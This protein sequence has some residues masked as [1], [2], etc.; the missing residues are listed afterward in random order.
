MKKFNY[1][2]LE[3]LTLNQEIVN[4]LL[5]INK[6]QSKNDLLSNAKNPVLK[7]YLKSAKFNSI[8]TSNQ[9]EG[10]KTSNYRME[11]IISSPDV[12]P[13]NH[14]ESE[15]IGYKKVLEMINDNYENIA[16]I[17]HHILQLHK[18]LFSFSFQKQFG[19][20]KIDNFIK[21]TFP[22]KTE[23]TRFI[24]SDA[25]ST[26][27]HME[28]LCQ[29]FNLHFH[30]PKINPL[31]ASLNFILDFLCIHPFTDGNGRISRLLTTL[32]L[33]KNDHIIQKF[34]SFEQIIEETKESYYDV[35]FES[36]QNWHENQ[37]DPLP[38]IQY[39]LNVILQTYQKMDFNQI[40]QSS[41]TALQ[42]ITNYFNN[43]IIQ[44]NK[45]TLI[46]KFPHISPTT[47]KLYL[48]KLVKVKYI[49]KVGNGKATTYIKNPQRN[50][51]K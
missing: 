34:I 10:I 22:D 27:Q 41:Q 31:I 2:N 4:I 24:P 35:L 6:F 23:K 28:E 20:K 49:L 47:I 50:A 7:K 39:M 48:H 38:F 8:T 14:P 15:I 36:S 37:N 32:L 33:Y 21:I 9:I 51:I 25:Y 5:E 40:Q 42:Q 18:I 43:S 44:T 46:K 1:E 12:K 13:K 45:A 11:K 17:P 19:Y 3:K 26:P 29:T 16:T 30:N